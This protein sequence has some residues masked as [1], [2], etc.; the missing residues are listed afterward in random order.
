MTDP[1]FTP[2]TPAPSISPDKGEEHPAQPKKRERK[3]RQKRKVRAA[4]NPAPNETP[5][6]PMPEKRQKRKPRAVAKVRKPRS[7]K[8]PVDTMLSALSS[9]KGDDGALFEKLLGILNAAGKPQ[10][11]RVMDA[12]SK[13]FA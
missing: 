6:M 11:S 2:F 4:M 12:L 13:V 8:L 7:M 1:I 3:T 10:R 5:M 9:L